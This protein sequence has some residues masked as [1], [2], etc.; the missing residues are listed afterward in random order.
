[1]AYCAVGEK[2]R[3][4]PMEGYGSPRRREGGG[5]RVLKVKLT[6]NF[7]G[8]RGRGLHI[9]RVMCTILKQFKSDLGA[10]GE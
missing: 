6:W 5:G 10:H 3:T 1:M 4:H 8:G 2:I 9:L 7:L